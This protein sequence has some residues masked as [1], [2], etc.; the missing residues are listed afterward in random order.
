[1]KKGKN[2]SK[3]KTKR[4]ATLKC[5]TKQETRLLNLKM[6]N[7]QWHLKQKNKAKNQTIKG[8]IQLNLKIK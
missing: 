3:R 4:Y 5:F 7:F 1:M 2:K 6:I 8:G